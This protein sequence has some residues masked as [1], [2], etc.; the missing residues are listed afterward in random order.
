MKPIKRGIKVW[1]LGDSTNGYFSR[2]QVY[3]GRQE[4]CEVG[5]GAHMVKTLTRDLNHKN[6]H[7]YFDNFFTSVQLLEQLEEDGIY[8]CG[9]ARKDR[10]GFLPALK[11]HGLRERYDTEYM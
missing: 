3:T 11:A 7:V 4:N 1:V 8:S 10:R 2:F 6:H 9:T 5:L